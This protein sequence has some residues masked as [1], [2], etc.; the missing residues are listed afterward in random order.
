M[1]T[2]GVSLFNFPWS[3]KVFI[4]LAVD[5]FKLFGHRKRWWV[6]G[7]WIAALILLALASVLVPSFKNGNHHQTYS[8]YVLIMTGVNLMIAFADVA[9]DGM[10]VA[11]TKL[12][13]EGKRGSVIATNYQCRFFAT[14]MSGGVIKFFFMNG[15]QFE[16]PSNPSPLFDHFGLDLQAIHWLLFA[17]ALPFMLCMFLWLE[18]P[19]LDKSEEHSTGCKGVSETIAV[20]WKSTQSYAVF[21]LV[22]FA[23]G[24]QSVGQMTNP[25]DQAVQDIS[26]PN[27]TQ[28]SFGTIGGYLLLMVG[29]QMYKRYLLQSNQRLVSTWCYIVS[30]LLQLAELAIVFNGVNMAASVSGWFYVIQQDLPQLTQAV[31]FCLVQ[32]AVAEIAPAGMEASVYEFLLTTSNIAITV[33]AIFTTLAQGWLGLSSLNGETFRDAYQHDPSKYH[34]YQN[35][36]VIGLLGTAAVSVASAFLFSLCLPS[37][38]QQCREWAAKKEWHVPS[39]STMN[40]VVL[41]FMIAWSLEGVILNV[42]D[43]Q[44]SWSDPL[45]NIM[46]AA[47]SVYALCGLG[48]RLLMLAKGD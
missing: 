9:A 16:D 22:I 14:M 17:L 1:C 30:A 13:P 44:V 6:V 48:Y 15:P 37:G 42:A 41:G 26:S 18:D 35:H 38:P 8:T 27:G 29:I 12:E 4:A 24:I 3:L 25:A 21:N 5:N 10:G 47:L 43:I 28:M 45:D 40:F 32:I 46:A 19:P 36:M 34:T 11:Y 31:A 7:G 2:L 23:I 39:V 20:M 33:G